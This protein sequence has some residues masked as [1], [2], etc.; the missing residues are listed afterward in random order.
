MLFSRPAGNHSPQA[1]LVFP[2][3]YADSPHRASSV[4][5]YH[6]ATGC[7]FLPVLAILR[8]FAKHLAHR[9]DRYT[10]NSQFV[11]APIVELQIV[12]SQALLPLTPLAVYASI[13]LWYKGDMA[14]VEYLLLANH[15]EVRGGL[16]YVSG[17]GWANLFRGSRNPDD[18]IPLSHFG[19]GAGFLIPYNETNQLHHIVARIA[20]EDGD[21]ELTRIQGN[22]EVGRPT[23][24]AQGAEQHIVV[25]L[26]VDVQFPEEGTYRVVVQIG[27]DERSVVFRVLDQDRP[28]HLS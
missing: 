25:G 9:P 4:W 20:K 24:L 11:A 13:H 8:P 27:K 10:M 22:M 16:L 5:A 19:I 28:L 3:T 6:L 7:T 14:T 12:Y 1:S 15:A 2:F 23:G 21:E 26:S 17:A 18:P